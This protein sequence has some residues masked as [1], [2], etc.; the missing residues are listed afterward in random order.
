M[1][2]SSSTMGVN[3][4]FLPKIVTSIWWL[5]K[6]TSI[7]LLGVITTMDLRIII[8]DRSCKLM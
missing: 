8:R 2:L 1:L 3:Q 6:V 5:I 7:G 4:K